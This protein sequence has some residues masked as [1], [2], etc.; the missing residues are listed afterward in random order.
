[1]PG[2]MDQYLD[3]LIENGFDSLE[4]LQEMTDNNLRSIGIKNVHIKILLSHV[5]RANGRRSTI[6]PRKIKEVE[7]KIT[8]GKHLRELAKQPETMQVKEVTISG[9]NFIALVHMLEN[10]VSVVT[11]SARVCSL[12]S[13]VSSAVACR[14][15]L[16]TPLNPPYRISFPPNRM[17]STQSHRL[18]FF[19]RI[20]C[21]QSGASSLIE[22]RSVTS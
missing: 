19:C 9:I 5:P 16:C 6:A 4:L 11:P 2:N 17:T 13:S 3:I 20:K 7:G 10:K 8:M 21:T 18:N 22:T 12:P 14:L 15:L 1:M